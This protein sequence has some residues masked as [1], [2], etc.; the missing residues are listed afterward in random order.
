MCQVN[1]LLLAASWPSVPQSH[2]VLLLALLYKIFFLFTHFLQVFGHYDAGISLG[3]SAR[4]N[5]S[6][7]KPTKAVVY[8][9]GRENLKFFILFFPGPKYTLLTADW[10][11][12]ISGALLPGDLDSDLTWPQL[13]NFFGKRFENCQIFRNFSILEIFSREFELDR[14]VRDQGGS[15]FWSNLDQNSDPLG[16]RPLFSSSQLN[17]WRKFWFE[18]VREKTFH[19]FC[20]EKPQ[21]FPSNYAHRPQM[22]KFSSRPSG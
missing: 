8:T 3:Q 15:D 1:L 19:Y 13:E 11:K 12:T 14:G 21:T 9:L 18:K 22:P 7:V 4:R 5:N 10:S 6:N 2:F 20:F 16:S 17:C